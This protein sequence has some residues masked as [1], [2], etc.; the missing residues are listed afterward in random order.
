MAFV[1]TAA[2]GQ[3]LV[4]V[5]KA[6]ERRNSRSMAARLRNK[7][8]STPISVEDLPQIEF[9][10]SLRQMGPVDFW[11]PVSM[12]VESDGSVRDI[13]VAMESSVTN[14]GFLFSDHVLS[15]LN[16]KQGAEITNELIRVLTNEMKDAKFKPRTSNGEGLATIVFVHSHFRSSGRLCWDVESSFRTSEGVFW[17]VLM[18]SPESVCD[19]PKPG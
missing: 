16:G 2:I 18:R 12:V 15:R 5:Y 11:I 7:P 19:A 3:G 4:H 10:K 9:P 17:S 14:E 13:D 8:I 1:L 6:G